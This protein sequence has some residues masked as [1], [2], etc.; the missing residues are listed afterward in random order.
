[1]SEYDPF[2]DIETLA[3]FDENLPDKVKFIEIEGVRVPYIPSEQ[4]TVVNEDGTTTV[5]DVPPVYINNFKQWADKRNPRTLNAAILSA[6]K[7]ILLSLVREMALKMKGYE[8]PIAVSTAVPVGHV[9]LDGDRIILNQAEAKRRYIDSDGDRAILIFNENKTQAVL[10]KYPITMQPL[11]L[12]VMNEIP[13]MKCYDFTKE[14]LDKIFESKPVRTW[15]DNKPSEPLETDPPELAE[16][17]KQQV[18]EWNKKHWDR[19]ALFM[20]RHKEVPVGLLTN[21]WNTFDLFKTAGDPFE[22]RIETIFNTFVQEDGKTQRAIDIEDFGMKA[23]RKEGQEHVDADILKFGASKALSHRHA[24]ALTSASSIGTMRENQ[25]EWVIGTDLDELV[26]DVRALKVGF[27]DVTPGSGNP[28]RPAP[29]KDGGIITRLSNLKLIRWVEYAHVDPTMPPSVMFLLQLPNGR[30]VGLTDVKRENNRSEGLTFAFLLAP[31]FDNVDIYDEDGN[32]KIPASKR[33]LHPIEHM[34]KIMSTF[35]ETEIRP[36]TNGPIYSYFP[37]DKNPHKAWEDWTNP[38][39]A[40]KV[41]MLQKALMEYCGR[42]GDPCPATYTEKGDGFRDITPS[43]Q[44][45]GIITRSI[46]I[47]YGRKMNEE[48]MYEVIQEALKSHNFCETGS[49]SDDR[50][51]RKYM[52]AKDEDGFMVLTPKNVHPYRPGMGRAQLQRALKPVKMKVAVIKQITENPQILITPTGIEKQFTDRAF[53][54]QVFSTWEAY[55]NHLKGHNLTEEDCPAYEKEFYTWTG[56]KRVAW[57]ISE[58]AAIKIGKLVDVLGNKFMPLRVGQVYTTNEKFVNTPNGIFRE[59]GDEIDLIM[60]IEE[61]ADK[62]AHHAFLKEAVEGEI[63]YNGEKVKCLI[64]ERN[65]YRTGS[66]SENIPPRHN[67]LCSFKGIDMYPIWNQVRKIRDVPLKEVN[68]SFARSLQAACK[69]L[70]AKANSSGEDMMDDEMRA[71]F[72]G[73]PTKRDYNQASFEAQR[74]LE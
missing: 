64:V 8:A 16:L 22:K 72:F 29:F 34:A 32:I 69:Q 7:E 57:T 62:Y 11:I 50:R 41:A 38:K 65:F 35:A 43:P 9:A 15:A 73:T 39:R 70:L 5:R 33:F 56:E 13:A 60:P 59:R 18:E 31:V 6:K 55:Q 19:K 3:F 37:S 74:P 21:A 63:E 27:R 47:D 23:T 30:E 20:K 42:Y 10:V 71:T 24:W 46:V 67:R 58:R 66:A 49:K 52:S 1:M 12:N 54:P 44:A 4:V 51:I 26:S 14:D 45:Y 61:L 68:T 28:D 36:F 48:E 40:I 53:L 25:L 17:K 2:N